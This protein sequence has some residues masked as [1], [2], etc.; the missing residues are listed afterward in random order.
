MAQWYAP[1]PT[2]AGEIQSKVHAG[3]CSDERGIM[4]DIGEL[5]VSGGGDLGVVEAGGEVWGGVGVPSA[6]GITQRAGK[7]IPLIKLF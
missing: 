5:F 3:D 6:Q 2:P 4:S 1:V 7:S